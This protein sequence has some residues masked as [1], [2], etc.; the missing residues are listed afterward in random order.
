VNVTAISTIKFPF[1]III[2]LLNTGLWAN[3]IR[4]LPAMRC[5]TAE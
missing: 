2:W 4:G 1:P 3:C 5:S